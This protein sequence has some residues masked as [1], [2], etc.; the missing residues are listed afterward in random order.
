[1]I[2]RLLKYET[3]IEVLDLGTGSGV[4]AIAKLINQHIYHGY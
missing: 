2:Q 1:M 4:L 3:P